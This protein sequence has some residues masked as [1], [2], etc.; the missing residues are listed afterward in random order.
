MRLRF[1]LFV[2]SAVPLV[3]SAAGFDC[4]KAASRVEKLICVDAEL[5]GLDDELTAAY[6]AA[7]RAGMP[8]SENRKQRQ[9]IV[10]RNACADKECVRESY[11]ARLEE[12]RELA[13]V[14][15]P[16]GPEVPEYVVRC[17]PANALL[18]I[19]EAG[20][21]PDASDSELI[22]QRTA[23]NARITEYRITPG[24]LTKAGGTD[25]QPLLLPAKKSQFQCRLGKSAYRVVIEPY[26][27]NA[28]VMGECGAA[29]P[30]ISATVF[31][32]SQS[33][34]PRQRFGDCHGR[35]IHRIQV[36]ERA[37]SM[38]VLVTL[39]GNFLPLHVEK[40]FPLAS[41]PKDLEEAVFDAFPTGDVD[42]DLF[43]AVRKRNVR[44][45]QEAL[46]RGA[47][48]NA[49]DLYGL[50]P[51]A[52]LWR[53]ETEYGKRRGDPE[54]DKQG[55]Q[56]ARLLFSKGAKGTIT[57]KNGVGV[58]LLPRLIGSV[59]SGVI[60][61]LLENGADPREDLSLRS[62]AAAG[63]ARLVERLIRA[64]ADPN[65]KGPDGATA[66]WYAAN[67]G[68]Y[69]S[70]GQAKPI[71]DYVQ[72]IR[73]LLKSGAKVEE[74]QPGPEGL[75]WFIVRG[76]WKDERIKL[77]LAELIPHSSKQSIKNAHELVG[78]IGS[79]SEQGIALRVWLEQYV[80]P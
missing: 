32:D 39:D 9:W 42:V 27:F 2:I 64:G 78:K 4:S 68:F 10:E 71:D 37:Q 30:V 8:E 67:S 1:F 62:A 61:L 74:A 20:V 65:R 75:L 11:K 7:R 36:S 23:R 55:E 28:R 45:V 73:I 50:T 29:E 69:T 58:S 22:S 53:A 46:A 14:I 80:R 16:D 70:N 21:T 49:Q 59:S 18:T 33:V 3:A 51:L 15:R 43:V 5:S 25:M 41:L 40:T 6:R 13:F 31:R 38:R 79:E 77:V 66:L 57:G 47:A 35:A 54:D 12:L 52:Y 44:L 76:F 72:C 19:E 34:L 48:P 17:D 24:D 56:I 60:E 63:N 26:I